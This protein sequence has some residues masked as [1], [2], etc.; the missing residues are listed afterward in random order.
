MET[1]VKNHLGLLQEQ[2]ETSRQDCGWM[3][4]LT[5]DSPDAESS[6]TLYPGAKSNLRDRVLCE[7]KK[8]SFIA[9]PG[10]GDT[11]G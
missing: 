1:V 7:V 4:S 9:L 5:Q 10:K 6:A 8:S 11:V 2:G 3:Y